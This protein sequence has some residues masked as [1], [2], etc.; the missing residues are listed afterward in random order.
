V[1]PDEAT[2]REAIAANTAALRA[3]YVA[4]DRHTVQ[5]D[6]LEYLQLLERE[7]EE[8]AARA[9]GQPPPAPGGVRGLVDAAR[10]LVAR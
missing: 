9:A 7:R 4:S 6:H 10:S 3:R 2:M 5:V 8:G 1:L